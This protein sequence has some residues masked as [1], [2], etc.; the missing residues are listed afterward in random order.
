M[1]VVDGQT[2]QILNRE[3]FGSEVMQ[4]ILEQG[5]LIISL[6][7]PDGGRIFSWV[8]NSCFSSFYGR[9]SHEVSDPGNNINKVKA[10]LEKGYVGTPN[11]A[12][13]AIY[14]CMASSRLN[15]SLELSPS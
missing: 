10:L 3:P 7:S 6:D 9:D 13:N 14:F 4:K 8:K 5:G 15:K 12:K 1:H 2:N 11:S